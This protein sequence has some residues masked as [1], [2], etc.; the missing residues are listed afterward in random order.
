M[1]SL[2]CFGQISRILILNLN[3]DWTQ[4]TSK[5]EGCKIA[6][7]LKFS[8]SSRLKCLFWTRR[9]PR[10]QGDSYWAPYKYTRSRVKVSTWQSNL[11]HGQVWHRLDSTWKSAPR[12][13]DRYKRR[14]NFT[15]RNH[16]PPPLL[17]R[18]G[19]SR[20]LRSTPQTSDRHSI[21]R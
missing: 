9:S 19:V 17:G 3:C 7:R 1:I 12:P 20:E 4:Q 8:K 16:L 2:N 5:G 15:A 14:Y 11:K 6:R 10:D 21:V 13:T 18:T